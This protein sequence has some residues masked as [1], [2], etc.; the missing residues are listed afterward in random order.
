MSNLIDI[1]H[2]PA[3][4]GLVFR[5]FRGPGDYPAM[6]RVANERAA[7]DGDAVSYTHLRAHAT[8]LDLV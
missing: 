1:P 5:H 3:L 2:S 4:P 7:A 6:V 8:V